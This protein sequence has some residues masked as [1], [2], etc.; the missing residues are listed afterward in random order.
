MTVLHVEDDTTYAS[1]VARLLS[2]L[3]PDLDLQCAST[4]AEALRLISAKPPRLILLDYRLPDSD[5]IQVLAEIRATQPSI[6]VIFLTVVASPRLIVQALRGGA[7]EYV[8]KD[9]E[10]PEVLPRVVTAIL[11]RARRRVDGSRIPETDSGNPAAA[12]STSRDPLMGLVGPSRAMA[13]VRAAVGIAAASMAPVLVEGETGTGK[14]LVARAIHT[15]G[16]RQSRPF[17]P[18]NCAAIPEPLAESEFFGHARGAFTGAYREKEG[19]FESARGGTLFLDEIEDLPPLLQA[20]LLRVLQDLEY[21]PIGTNSTRRADVR[22]IAASNQSPAGL[23]QAGRLRPDLYYR[24]RVLSIL[25]P[26]IR[27][28][29]EDIPAL[30]K[31][32]I[33]RFNRR[34]DADLGPLP[35]TFLS[36]LCGAPWPGN[37]RELENTLESLCAAAHASNRSL[38]R[39]VTE[40]PRGTTSFTPL[41]ER[42]ALLHTLEMHHW[43]RQAAARALGISRVTLWRRMVRLGIRGDTSA[44]LDWSHSDVWT[45]KTD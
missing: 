17:V 36:R 30:C 7:V 33:G 26:P 18:V 25:V 38:A 43:S 12:D 3:R 44:P 23:V 14:E 42:S 40:L 15:L 32:F 5:G 9:T 10:L 41:D 31:H 28:R 34:Y 8:V 24:L 4:A 11:P 35:P 37:V 27:L 21:R 29:R 1:L 39:V 6:P 22:I 20:K 13:Q 45:A 2:R 16:T 19:L